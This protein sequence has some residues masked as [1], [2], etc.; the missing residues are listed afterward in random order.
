MDREIGRN[1]DSNAFFVV[2]SEFDESNE[3][4]LILA[5][6]TKSLQ[7][8]IPNPTPQSLLFSFPNFNVSLLI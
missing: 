4:F 7:Y 3:L 6:I 1:S 5:G 2:F 8:S